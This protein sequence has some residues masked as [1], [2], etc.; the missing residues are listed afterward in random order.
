MKPKNRKD[1]LDICQNNFFGYSIFTK[2][3]I[4]ISLILSAI[5]L[6]IYICEY[7]YPTLCGII[8]GEIVGWYIVWRICLAYIFYELLCGI[9]LLFVSLGG[10]AMCM[11]ENWDT[12]M[13]SKAWMNMYKYEKYFNDNS[14][15]DNSDFEK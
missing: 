2:I 11:E 3:L 7:I 9:N 1:I 12:L 15:D 5:S 14:T 8:S 6:G 10:A 4:I 13:F